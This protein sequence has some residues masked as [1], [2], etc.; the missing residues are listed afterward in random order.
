MSTALAS[1]RARVKKMIL[2]GDS[3]D[4]IKETNLT[5]SDDDYYWEYKI[6]CE[7]DATA[8]SSTWGMNMRSLNIGHHNLG[9]GSYRAA[10][11]K[12]DKEDADRREKNLPPIFEKFP[13]KQTRNFLK[14]RYHLDPKTK[15][16]TA[17]LEVEEL[18]HFLAVFD[19]RGTWKSTAEFG[20]PPDTTVGGLPVIK[21]SRCALRRCVHL[22]KDAKC[23][24][25][26]CNYNKLDDENKFFFVKL[27]GDFKHQTII[28]EQFVRRLKGEISREIKIETRNGCSY[29]VTVAKYEAKHVLTVGWGNFVERLHLEMGDALLFRYNGNSLF[30]A[31]IFDKLGNEKALSVVIDP[32]LPEVQTSR[33]EEHGNGSA[34]KMDAGPCERCK[35]WDEY[36][37]MNLDDEK[38]YLLILTMGDFQDELI[39]PKEFVQRLKGEIPASLSRRNGGDSLRSLVYRWVTAYHRQWKCIHISSGLSQGNRTAMNSSSLESAGD[40]DSLS[41]SFSSEDVHN[42]RDLPG[43]SRIVRKKANLTTVQKQQL[44][45]GYIT[46]HKTKLT[47]A[48]RQ[49]VKEKVQSIHSEITIFVAKMSST[50]VTRGFIMTVP[51]KYAEKYL[52]YEE[53]ICFQLLGR[54]W[55]VSFSD[56][57]EDYRV[58][59]GWKKF[60]QDNNLKKDDI[61]LFELLSNQRRSM[62]DCITMEVYIIRGSGG[63]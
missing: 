38:N 51:D 60:V 59:K 34:R 15:V 20:C 40:S 30:M 35:I 24:M 50:N 31:I 19:S 42:A 1:W 32:F 7:S 16:L 61:C 4:N 3:Y 52:R 41:G 17:D 45:D 29:P 23:R 14:S 22:V 2:K 56:L 55:K 47:Y 12:W 13:D 46:T 63:N 58:V 57:R 18:E 36:D 62:E 39:I 27:I 9:P 10:Q 43:S 6:K 37:Y 44:K 26:A 25:S 48:Q 53:R 54:K 28:P 5:I 33:N 49:Q 11:S 8:Q 21:W